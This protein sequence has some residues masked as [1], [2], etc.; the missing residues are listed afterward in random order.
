MN[1]QFGNYGNY[2]NDNYGSHCLWFKDIK[3][4]TFYFSYKTLVAFKHDYKT[5]I[6]NQWS[7]TTGKH[8]NWIDNGNKKERLTP[9]QFEAKYKDCFGEDLKEVA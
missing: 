1:V 5:Y 2:S 8:L 9:E 6:Q 3:G 4:N 7:T